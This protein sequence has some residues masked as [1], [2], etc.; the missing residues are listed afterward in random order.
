[1]VIGLIMICLSAGNILGGRSAD[2]HKSLNRLYFYIWIASLW[3][4]VIPFIGKYL[5]SL[6]IG[7]LVLFAP[8]GQ[9]VVMGSAISCLVIFS[10]PLILLA[11][12]HRIL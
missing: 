3:I 8:G 7:I 6:I 9:F 11:W 4:A 1:V 10:L 5:I 2:K 12:F